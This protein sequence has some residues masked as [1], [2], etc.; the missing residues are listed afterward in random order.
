MPVSPGYFVSDCHPDRLLAIYKVTN[1]SGPRS[2]AAAPRQTPDHGE[3]V[4]DGLLAKTVPELQ[5]V[6][7]PVVRVRLHLAGEGT[8]RPDELLANLLGMERL[9]P[10]I[11]VRTQLI[12]QRHRQ[13][14]GILEEGPEP[15]TGSGAGT[16]PE[17]SAAQ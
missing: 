14:F 4:E 2:L 11:V 1:G 16:A 13:R 17:E 8:I 5:D 6:S 7:G 10:P 12:C 3:R 9:E 15:L